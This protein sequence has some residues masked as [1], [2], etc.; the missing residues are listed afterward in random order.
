[1]RTFL[2]DTISWRD[3]TNVYFKFAMDFLKPC[4][5]ETL[6]QGN[7]PLCDVHKAACGSH[8][9]T[10]KL[11]PAARIT[12]PHTRW[13]L[14]FKVL[15]LSH[16]PRLALVAAYLLPDIHFGELPNFF[17]SNPVTAMFWLNQYISLCWIIYSPVSSASFPNLSCCL[18]VLP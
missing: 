3:Q 1:M 18:S 12:S 13:F 7:I 8:G 2:V 9:H 17:P 6:L 16:M 11:I 5:R 10:S 14:C 4:Y 15:P